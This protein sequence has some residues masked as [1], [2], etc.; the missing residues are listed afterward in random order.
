MRLNYL[1]KPKFQIAI[2]SYVFIFYLVISCF[3]Y[4]SNYT[5]IEKMK[6]FGLDAKLEANSSYFSY[7]SMLQEYSNYYFLLIFSAGLIAVITFGLTISHRIAGPIYKIEKVL[8]A[9][10]NSDNLKGENFEIK[11]RKKDFFQNLA[12]LINKLIQSKTKNEE[13]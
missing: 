6:Q 7:I 3:F 2:T 10:N 8:T 1:I 12:V 13:D 4:L 9:L 11:L 5:L